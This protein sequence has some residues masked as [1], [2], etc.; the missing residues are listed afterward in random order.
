M[1]DAVNGVKGWRRADGTG[2]GKRANDGGE[3]GGPMKAA[4]ESEPING[5][6]EREPMTGGRRRR[7]RRV[8]GIITPSV[9]R[10]S[11]NVNKIILPS[12]VRRTRLRHSEPSSGRNTLQKSV[13]SAFR[14]DSSRNIIAYSIKKFKRVW[15]KLRSVPFMRYFSFFISP[16]NNIAYNLLR[17]ADRYA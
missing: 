9:R 5:G 12:L 7:E 3:R 8:E 13:S 16:R 14:V 2:R 1:V 10:F 15:R 4:G 17:A 6:R 11:F